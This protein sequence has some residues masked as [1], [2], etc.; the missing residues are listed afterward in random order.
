MT[1]WADAI[2]MLGMYHSDNSGAGWIVLLC[3]TDQ[4]CCGRSLVAA[5]P[6]ANHGF[7]VA[8]GNNTSLLCFH[9]FFGEM[10]VK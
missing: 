9:T 6:L 3:M 4:S 7:R 5:P 1:L 8:R 10:L 2:G